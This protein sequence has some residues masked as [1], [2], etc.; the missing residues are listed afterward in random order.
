MKKVKK[1][2]IPI[3]LTML[4]LFSMFSIPT[5]MANPIDRNL[6]D[7]IYLIDDSTDPGMNYYNAAEHATVNSLLAQIDNERYDR[8]SDSDKLEALHALYS[9]LGASGFETFLIESLRHHGFTEA[10]ISELFEPKHINGKELGLNLEGLSRWGRIVYGT[11]ADVPNNQCKQP[12]DQPTTNTIPMSNCIDG[13]G[14]PRYIGISAS[15]EYLH[16][17]KFPPDALENIDVGTRNWLKDSWLHREHIVNSHLPLQTEFMDDADYPR[18]VRESWLDRI[19]DPYTGNNS[20]GNFDP[21]WPSS[22]LVDYAVIEQAPLNFS[23]GQATI[24]HRSYYSASSQSACTSPARSAGRHA[25]WGKDYMDLTVNGGEYNSLSEAP[26]RCFMDWY[27]TF[28]LLPQYDIFTLMIEYWDNLYITQAGL[29]VPPGVTWENTSIAQ[30]PGTPVDLKVSFSGVVPRATNND[31]REFAERFLESNGMLNYI[32]VNGTV[33][34]PVKI[35]FVQRSTDEVI[36][37]RPAVIQDGVVE[38]VT[39]TWQYPETSDHVDVVILADYELNPHFREQHI[40]DN[41]VELPL[42]VLGNPPIEDP[43]ILP[44]DGLDNIK[45]NALIPQPG[46]GGKKPGEAIDYVTVVQADLPSDY[47]RV[48]FNGGSRSK[49]IPLYPAVVNELNRIDRL[50]CGPNARTDC[51]TVSSSGN[52]TASSTYQNWEYVSRRCSRGIYDSEG[53]R[54]GTRSYECGSHQWVTRDNPHYNSVKSAVDSLIAAWPDIQA[55][56]TVQGGTCTVTLERGGAEQACTIRGV[57]PN[58]ESFVTTTVEGHGIL[59]TRY[60][61]N[62][63]RVMMYPILMSENDATSS[64]GSFEYHQLDPNTGAPTRNT[65]AEPA[66]YGQQVR[67][68]LSSTANI[69][70]METKF[71][72]PLFR[73]NSEFANVTYGNGRLRHVPQN[74]VLNVSGNTPSATYNGISKQSTDNKTWDNDFQNTQVGGS[75]IKYYYDVE[76]RERSYGQWTWYEYE[77]FWANCTDCRDLDGNTR[78]R[79]TAQVQTQWQTK[80]DHHWIVDLVKTDNSPIGYWP[81][82]GTLPPLKDGVPTPISQGGK[83]QT[84]KPTFNYMHNDR[85]RGVISKSV[86]GPDIHMFGTVVTSVGGGS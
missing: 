60:D 59:E 51:V 33:N 70:H 54:I 3:F 45:V 11:P 9:M 38:D 80:P 19:V 79:V 62:E 86:T 27:E 41:I 81:Q 32:E 36:A 72:Y 16:N 44:G 46:N 2:M 68:T 12:G 55:T 5:T 84:V 76:R 39:F 17:H 58:T 83:P 7:F 78:P 49:P 52:V 4:M 26:N 75:N 82:H 77:V 47:V 42:P 85:T 14:E 74:S 30:P 23:D 29:A 73:M 66:K 13:D 34:I 40:I 50:D 64:D 48:S 63:A 31:I 10:V 21:D 67:I 57:M 15:G 18:E 28:T 35:Y 6:D 1:R 56:V 37:V 20:R 43:G 53:N 65:Q 69:E 61:D 25:V 22:V 8:M 24:W 71:D